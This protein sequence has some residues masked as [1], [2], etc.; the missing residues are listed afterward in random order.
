MT[1]DFAFRVPYASVLYRCVT[2][3]ADRYEQAVSDML[4]E[5]LREGYEVLPGWHQITPEHETTVDEAKARHYTPSRQVRELIKIYAE[6]S[7]AGP[8]PEWMGD[9]EV[10]FSSGCRH[11]VA[12]AIRALIRAESLIDDADILDELCDELINDWKINRHG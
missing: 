2:V 9:D 5:M 10:G 6:M 12:M 11:G 8:R 3:R 1:R 4:L 7:N